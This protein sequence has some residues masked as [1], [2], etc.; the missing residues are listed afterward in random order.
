MLKLYESF[1]NT[2]VMSLRIGGPI[3]N[4]IKPIINPNNLFIEGWHVIDNK[5]GDNL[6]LL[7]QDIRDVLPQGLVVNDHEVLSQ[8]EDLVRLKEV[9]ELDFELLKLRVYSQSGKNYGKVTDFAFETQSCYVQKLYVAQPLLR[10]F[11]GGTL[12][13]DRTQ[14]IEITNK[15]VIIEDPTIK[16]SQK[17]H[18]TSPVV[19]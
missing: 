14:I 10:N 13:I 12:S 2:K 5:N 7:S 9:L 16:A 11:T 3:A 19:S 8:P 1:Q 15:R 17:V 6:I 18:A 4:V